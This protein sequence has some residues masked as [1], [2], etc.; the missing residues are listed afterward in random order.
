MAQDDLENF[1]AYRKSRELFDFVV[2][3]MRAIEK[4]PAC[5]RLIG[6][7][8][9]SA[10]SICANMEEGYGRWSQKE[11]VQ[12]LLYSRGSARESR[13][14]YERLHHWLPETTV[15]ARVALCDEI[16][17]ILTA[18]VRRLRENPVPRPKRCQRVRAGRVH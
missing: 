2:E 6:Q 9:A 16:I 12:F 18:S 3:D 11:Y 1:G 7:Q 15:A 14:R 5:W 17:A 13:G 4:I 10:D 8:V